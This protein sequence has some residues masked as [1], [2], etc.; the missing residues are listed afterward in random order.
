MCG[1]V[2]VRANDD[3]CFTAQA[4]DFRHDHADATANG[5]AYTFAELLHDTVE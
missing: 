3:R 4:R 2:G 5:D 1:Q